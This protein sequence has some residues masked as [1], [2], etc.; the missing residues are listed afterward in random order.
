MTAANQTLFPQDKPI[1]NFDLDQLR[2]GRSIDSYLKKLEETVNYL[3]G[4]L[5]K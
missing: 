3:S 4:K 1:S 5:K 2:Q